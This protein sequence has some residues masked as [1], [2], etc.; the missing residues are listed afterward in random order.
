M[1]FKWKYFDFQY[2]SGSITSF[3]CIEMYDFNL[4]NKIKLLEL[5]DSAPLMWIIIFQVLS[6]IRLNTVHI[7]HFHN[8]LCV[9]VVFSI[10]FYG[11]MITTL[12]THHIHRHTQCER[13]SAIDA[14][15][16]KKNNKWNINASWYIHCSYDMCAA[17]GRATL[18]IQNVGSNF[19]YVVFIVENE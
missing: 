12:K 3:K 19:I 9:V 14:N 6:W 13:I 2:A 5:I 11:S 17:N 7:I 18:K 15:K 8:S 1:Y 10:S 4:K 16:L